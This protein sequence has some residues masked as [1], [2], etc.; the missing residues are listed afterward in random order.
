[1]IIVTFVLTA[2]A[3]VLGAIEAYLMLLSVASLGKRA[4]L[5]GVPNRLRR[6]AILI[7]AHDEEVVLPSTLRSLEKLEYP[8]EAFDIHV[9]ADNCRDSTADIVRGW[10]GR[11]RPT[12]HV[13]DDA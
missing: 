7:P 2:V 11:T 6:F 13:R 12:V 5:T 3:T 10:Q 4:P 8:L 1:M 9:I